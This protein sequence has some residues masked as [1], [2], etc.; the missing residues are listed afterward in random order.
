MLHEMGDAP[1]ELDRVDE[2]EPEEIK[3]RRSRMRR[4]D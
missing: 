1:N 4:D 2:E 3:K